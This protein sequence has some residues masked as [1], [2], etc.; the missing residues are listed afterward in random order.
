MAKRVGLGMAA[1]I[2]PTNKGTSIGR[3]NIKMASMN[4]NRKRSFKKYRGQG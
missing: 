3:K 4:K 2:E 1:N